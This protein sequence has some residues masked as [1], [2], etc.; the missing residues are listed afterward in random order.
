MKLEVGLKTTKKKINFGKFVTVIERWLQPCSEV[1]CYS[2][3][4]I[5]ENDRPIFEY[6]VYSIA[7][8]RSLLWHN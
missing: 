3:Q 4:S 7:Y 2:Q 8:I 6:I 1:H 5:G